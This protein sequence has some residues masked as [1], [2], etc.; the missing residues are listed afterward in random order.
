MIPAAAND[1][2]TMTKPEEEDKRATHPAAAA[3]TTMEARPEEGDEP[4]GED[5]MIAKA[6]AGQHTPRQQQ[7]QQQK[8]SQRRATSPEMTAEVKAKAGGG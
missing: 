8:R 5:N 4:R 2:T 3:K 7:K 1:E 6:G